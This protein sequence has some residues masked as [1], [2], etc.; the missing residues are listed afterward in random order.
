MSSADTILPG[1]EM[2]HSDFARSILG[3]AMAPERVA[4][5]VNQ[6][7]GDSFSVGPMPVGPVGLAVASARG[8]PE[9]VQAEPSDDP[10]WNVNLTVPVSLRVKVALRGA[11]LVPV[12]VEY[13][14]RVVAHTRL[15]LHLESPGYVVV[16][17]ESVRREN[18]ETLV[19]PLDI[20]S[21]LVGWLGKINSVVAEHVVTYFNRLV[22]S[23][24]IAKNLRIDV[25]AIVEKAFALGLPVTTLT[26]G[27]RAS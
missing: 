14:I 13:Q 23:P 20:P 4:A 6:T 8:R 24:S 2:S 18:V 16:D 7:L 11:G 19:V 15:R 1:Q 26:V 10:R 3:A 22:D 12:K 17:V 9:T 25:L 5:L 27:E 21:R